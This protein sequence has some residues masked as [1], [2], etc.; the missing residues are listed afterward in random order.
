MSYWS[1]SSGL[2]EL[3]ITKAQARDCSH[4]GSCDAEVSALSETPAIRKQLDAL[5]PVLVA[6]ELSE[7]GAWDEDELKDHNQ[8][9]QRIL[10][11]ACGDLAF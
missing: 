10:W 5:N 1:S 7:Y 2:I 3:K 4:P 9:L 6:D 8:N 11:I